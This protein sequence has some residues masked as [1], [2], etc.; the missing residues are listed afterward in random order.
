MQGPEFLLSTIVVHVALQSRHAAPIVVPNATNLII[1][2]KNL[3]RMKAVRL[4]FI[5]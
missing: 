5:R 4:L 3:A 1:I 2:R